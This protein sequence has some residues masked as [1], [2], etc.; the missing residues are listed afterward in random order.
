M[1]PLVRRV[2]FRWA[3]RFEPKETKQHKV[4][5]LL[6]KIHEL[7]G[8]SKTQSED[9]ADALVRGRNI[10]SLSLQKSWP[11]QNGVVHGPR[12][13]FDLNTVPVV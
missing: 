11:V 4:D 10:D 5:V 9:I 3:F 7:T 6:K 12:G 8:I 13:T 2:A 1:D